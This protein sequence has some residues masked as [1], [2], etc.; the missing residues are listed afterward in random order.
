[1]LSMR[2]PKHTDYTAS[3]RSDTGCQ[4]CSLLYDLVDK[5]IRNK[6]DVQVWLTTEEGKRLEQEQLKRDAEK[7]RERT[8]KRS[9]R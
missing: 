5:A 8:G 1:M 6:I 3:L 2:C 4:T 9:K 7:L